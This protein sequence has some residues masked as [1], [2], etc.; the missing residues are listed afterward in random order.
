MFRDLSVELYPREIVRVGGPA[1]SGTSALLQVFAGV[2]APSR[3]AIRLRTPTVGYVPQHFGENLPLSA[4]EYLTW[5]GRMRGLR[6]DVRQA[7]ISQLTRSFELGT[8]AGLRLAGITGNREQLARRIV[9]MQALLDEPAM[10]VLDNPWVATDA[11]LRDLLS[12]RVLELSAAGCL[13]IF[14]G[15]APALRP[16]RYLTLTGG[17][18]QDT[19]YDPAVRGDNYLRCELAGKGSDLDGVPGLIEQHKHPDGLVVIVDRAHSDE[20]ILR[21]VQGGWSIRRVEPNR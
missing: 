12:R 5:L 20:L 1:G 2:V 3:G 11:H 15:Y 19:D 7:R 17:R 9:I 18:V 13:I 14:T 21:A 4:E 8:S 10:L 6:P 16:S